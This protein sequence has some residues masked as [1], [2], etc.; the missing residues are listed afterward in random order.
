MRS[1][2]GKPTKKEKERIDRFS[3]VGCVACRSTLGVYNSQYDIHHIIRGNRRVGHWFTIPLCPQHHRNIYDRDGE[4]TSIA[5]GSKAFERIH[6]SEESL[7]EKTQYLL[8][9]PREMKA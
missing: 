9:L 4:W 6:G 1:S 8:G 7:W 3:V 2:L 5:H